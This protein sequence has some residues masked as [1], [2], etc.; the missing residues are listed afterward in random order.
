M[1]EGDGKDEKEGGGGDAGMFHEEHEGH[2]QGVCVETG[3][4]EGGM[5]GMEELET[6]MVTPRFLVCGRAERRAVT[7][8]GSNGGGEFWGKMMSFHC[9]CSG[10]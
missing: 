3:W 5:Q 10:I 4:V 6:A 8:M 7:Q 2:W 9:R 1:C